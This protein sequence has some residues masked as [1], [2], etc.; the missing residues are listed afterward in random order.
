MPRKRPV[1]ET[2]LFGNGRPKYA[3]FRIDG[4]MHGAWSLYRT[5]GSLMRT[6]EFDGGR[7]VG[8]WRTFDR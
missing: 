2:V 7:R 4:E 6:G 3:G 5:G 8:T 1:E